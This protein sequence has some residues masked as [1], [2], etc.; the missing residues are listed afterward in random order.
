MCWPFNH[1]I[2]RTFNLKD[3][4]YITFISGMCIFLELFTTKILLLPTLKTPVFLLCLPPLVMKRRHRRFSRKQSFPES[5]AKTSRKIPPDIRCWVEFLKL[6]TEDK[7]NVIWFRM[8]DSKVS[9]GVL[10]GDSYKGVLFI[11]FRV[12]G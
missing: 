1:I 3:T 10:E 9:Q 7:R 2:D 8:G 4:V 5:Q 12:G 11:L 6:G